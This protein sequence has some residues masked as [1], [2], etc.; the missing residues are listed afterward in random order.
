ME[1]SRR[2]RKTPVKFLPDDAEERGAHA[3]AKRQKQAAARGAAA[4][5]PAS[6]AAAAA[7]SD[8]WLRTG[9]AWIGQVCLRYFHHM[10][11]QGTIVAWM[12]ATD[13]DPALWRLRHEDGD[14]EDLEEAEVEAGIEAMRSARRSASQPT[15][16]APAE[17]AQGRIVGEGWTKDEDDE[18]KGMVRDEGAG[19]WTAKAARFST[20]RSAN[21]LR[22]R[23]NG[24]LGPGTQPLRLEEEEA[25]EEAESAESE[26]ESAEDEAEYE[27]EEEAE[28]GARPPVVPSPRHCPPRGSPGST[29]QRRPASASLVQAIAVAQHTARVQSERR[30]FAA[31]TMRAVMQKRVLVR[32][33]AEEAYVGTVSEGDLDQRRVLVLYDDGEEIWEEVVK[34]K[35]LVIPAAHGG[36]ALS[37]RGCGGQE[38]A[39]TLLFC[40]GCDACYHRQC[41]Q[42]VRVQMKGRVASKF[43][44]GECVAKQGDCRACKGSHCSHTCEDGR[45]RIRHNRRSTSISR[46]G[47]ARPCSFASTTSQVCS[48]QLTA[49]RRR[50]QVPP[51]VILSARARRSVAGWCPSTAHPQPPPG[52]ERAHQRESRRG[53]HTAGVRRG[54]VSGRLGEDPHRAAGRTRAQLVR[55]HERLECQ[56]CRVC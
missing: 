54:V 15:P 56:P 33:N 44:C 40:P 12:P 32:W 42:E 37:C 3:G 17:A 53:E 34:D 45:W 23:W 30:V 1:R 10:P 16:A 49:V 26:A 4:A 31:A 22:N 51:A 35:F 28:A 9:S 46:P 5:E 36:G 38:A 2:K 39:A 21:S 43:Y 13:E 41:T 7:G 47:G 14:Q 19:G 29:R 11:V 50:R 8:V 20:Q 18:L 24:R 27:E 6:P 52:A 25:E 55:G 48:M